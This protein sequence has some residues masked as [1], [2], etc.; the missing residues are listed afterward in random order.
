MKLKRYIIALV[1]ATGL[2][3]GAFANEKTAVWE[4]IYKNAINDDMRYAVLLNIQELHDPS[5]SD[6]LTQA[7]ADLVSSRIESS[8]LQRTESKVRLASLLIQELG[9]LNAVAAADSIFAVFQESANHPFLQAEAAMTL[10][11]LHAVQYEPFLVRALNDSNLAPNPNDSQ[12]QE[13]VAF[14]LVQGL[15][16]MHDIRSYEP[17]FYASIGWYSPERKVK[18]TAAALLKTIVADPTDVLVKIINTQTNYKK[19]LYALDAENDSSASPAAKNKTALVAMEQ[20]IK[21][22]PNNLQESLQLA[23]LR[24]KAL[25]MLIQYQDHSADAVKLYRQEY[26]TAKSANQQS[27]ILTMIQAL[28]IN[29]S[30]AAAGYLSDLLGHFNDMSTNGLMLS[31]FDLLQLKTVLWAMQKARNPSVRPG[32][33]QAQFLY[34]PAIQRDVKDVLASLPAN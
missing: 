15:A 33:L 29:A 14:G 24:G 16:L 6:M 9:Q 21:F 5:F 22:I 8:D 7:L 18:E 31:D 27:E 4:R 10:G 28:G 23:N 30:P 19:M 1:M 34:T 17:V 3:L 25:S 32:L 20:G 13:I 11:Q 26:Q 12:A 2:V